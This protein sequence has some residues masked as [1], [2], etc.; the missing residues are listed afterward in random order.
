MEQNGIIEPSTSHWSSPVV[1][2][3]KKNDEFRFAIDYRN[4]VTIPMS[5]PLPHL[6]SVFDCIGEAQAKFFSCLDMRSSF[7]QVPLD[8]ESQIKSAF[9]TQSGVYQW[10][11]MP[12]G[13]RNSSITFASM[14]SN[15]LRGL[16]WKSVLVYIDDILIFSHNFDEHLSH[17]AQVFS[18]LNEANLRLH[19]SKCHFAV[20]QL[21]FD[22]VEVN[23]EKTKAVSEFPTPKTQTQVRSFL[24]MA[25]FYRRFIKNHSDI[26]APLN[27]LLRKDK[28]SVVW[29]PDYEKAF[30]TIKNALISAPVLSY[31]KSSRPF[32]LTCDASDLAISYILGQKDENGREYVIAY[33][34]KALTEE[35]R[36][37]STSDKECYAIIRGI[38]AYRPYLAGTHFTIVT[39]HRALV[40][41]QSAKHTG[42]LERWALK[43]QYLTLKLFTVLVKVML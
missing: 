20:K 28:K 2:V 32:I 7:W 25:N 9:I 4:K 21:K 35:E 3:K 26:V 36:K 14:M 23:P 15:V 19:P 1:L 13:L 29:T 16:N 12:F 43:I 30:E 41:L 17:L 5:F 40:W 18:R 31:A 11:R 27:A 33:G 8:K 22:G 39:D 38:Q 34:G 37:W 42:R 10:K 24:G 6:D